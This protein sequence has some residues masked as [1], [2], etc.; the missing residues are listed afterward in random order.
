M[1]IAALKRWSDVEELWHEVRDYSPSGDLVNE[2]RIV[3]AG[4][5]ADQG[6]L[7]GA[8]RAA[9]EGMGADATAA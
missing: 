9:G 1:P 2:G 3:A 4:A 8:H 7:R 6:D 5:L